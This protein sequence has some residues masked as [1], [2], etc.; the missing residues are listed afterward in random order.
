MESAFVRDDLTF[1]LSDLMDCKGQSYGVGKF[2]HLESKLHS[3]SWI[4]NFYSGS[5]SKMRAHP[6]CVVLSR[7]NIGLQQRE[8]FSYHAIVAG[9][10]AL[11]TLTD[12]NADFILRLKA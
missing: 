10:E 5:T 12:R 1:A 6:L 2:L 3:T 7:K 9:A 8:M 11:Y 4:A